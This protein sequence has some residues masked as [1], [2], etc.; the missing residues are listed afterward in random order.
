MGTVYEA[1]DRQTGRRVALKRIAASGASSA[2]AIERFRREGRLAST[3]AHPRCVFVY[4]ADEDQGQPYIVME[5]MPGDTLK[6]LVEQQGPL[7]PEQAVAKILD[8]IEGLHETHRHGVIHRDVKPSNCF[9]DGDGRVKIGDFGLAKS[10]VSD[11]HLTRTGAF[12]GTVLFASPEQVRKDPLDQ[13]T[14]VYSVAATFYYLLTGRAPFQ[15]GDAAA[16]LARIVADPPPPIRSLR[17]EIPAALDQVVLRGLERHRQRRW[18]DL[19]AFRAALEPFAPRQFSI[20]GVGLRIG[21]YLIDMVLLTP[22][23]VFYAILFQNSPHPLLEWMGGTVASDLHWFLYFV[24]LEGIWGCSLG[25]HWLR[26]RIYGNQASQPPG[27]RRA[28]VRALVFYA[29]LGFP[30]DLITLAWSDEASGPYGPWSP[31][32]AFV[33]VTVVGWLILA[34]P[35]RARSGYRGVHDWLSGTRVVRLPWSSKRRPFAACR[36]QPK[37]HPAGEM[38]ER[39]GPFQIEGALRWDTEAKLLL[40]QDT[41]LGRRVWIQVR[42]LAHPPLTP[43]RRE[44]SRTT[45]L[46]WLASSQHGEFQWDAFLAPQS[47]PLSEILKREGSFTWTEARPLLE[48]LTTELIEAD[49]DQTLPETLTVQQVWVQTDGRAQLLDSPLDVSALQEAGGTNKVEPG[50]ALLQQVAVWI[51]EGRARA[52]ESRPLSIRVPVPGHACRI[53]DRLL[54]VVPDSYARVEQFQEDLTATHERPTEVTRAQRAAHLALLSA[55]LLI[56]LPFPFVMPLASRQLQDGMLRDGVAQIH[57]AQTLRD[58]LPEIARRDFL[59]SVPR[60]DPLLQALAVIRLHEDR[61]LPL[62]LDN[63]IARQR[64]ILSKLQQ[65]AS[66]TA[67]DVREDDEGSLGPAPLAKDAEDVRVVARRI[68][69]ENYAHPRWDTGVLGVF[70]PIICL[71]FLGTAVVLALLLRVG[72]TLP[73]MGITLLRANGR[74]ALRIQCAWRAFLVWAPVMALVSLSAWLHDQWLKAWLAQAPTGWPDLLSWIPWGLALALLPTYLGLA[75]W[76]PTRS[77]QDRLAGTYL[78]PR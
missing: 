20:G 55:V 67:S 33:P 40:G 76:R 74:K 19:E 25:K 50:L 42:P 24:F 12:L 1:E 70:I 77:V 66:W 6:D 62:L 60:P 49:R 53:L 10:L 64:A 28:L 3:I 8:V 61:E 63:A 31:L 2:E 71:T 7:P 18:H 39:L 47:C 51:L 75:I 54:G 4:A 65:S 57:Q 56:P 52:G 9:L 34:L 15:T 45:R 72:W 21:A 41:V 37:T 32:I 48:Q 16:T 17:P 11:S 44:I 43:A 14:D 30:W 73:L 78:V 46:R 13:Q 27:L 23:F 58:S 29:L 36:F 38:P 69:R 35:M 22:F 26:L 68:A 59:L 5:L